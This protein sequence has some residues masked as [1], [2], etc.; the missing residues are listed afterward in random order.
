MTEIKDNAFFE[1]LFDQFPFALI[2]SDAENSI[3]YVNSTYSRIF[4]TS[5]NFEDELTCRDVFA[6][7]KPPAKED[8]ANPVKCKNCIFPAGLKL[9]LE[10]GQTTK[11]KQWIIQ[12]DDKQNE[13]IRLVEISVSPF[14]YSNKKYALTI[15]EDISKNAEIGINDGEFLAEFMR[16]NQ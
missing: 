1:E 3:V 14:T 4:G 8:G 6:C 12:H 13:G 11:R 7:M 10:K 15:L 5:L 16:K 9:A 2:V